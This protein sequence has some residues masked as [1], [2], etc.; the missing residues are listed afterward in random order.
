IQKLIDDGYLLGEKIVSKEILKEHAY[1]ACYV[2]QHPKLPFIS[3]PYEWCFSALQAAAL[4]QLKIHLLALDYGVTLIDASSYNIQF[5]GSQ[6]V[7]I[8]HLSFREY[9]EGDLWL[10]QQQ[11][12]QQFLYP[13]LLN[14]YCQIP[15]NDWFRGHF[16]GINARDL[17]SILPFR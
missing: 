4:L 9:H 10:G 16:T 15:F 3:Y 1:E 13:L 8:D 5:I 11:F 6:P 2:L 7:F 14:A 12:C 17:K